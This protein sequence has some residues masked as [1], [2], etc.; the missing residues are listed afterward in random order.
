MS[1]L[2]RRLSFLKFLGESFEIIGVEDEE[3]ACSIGIYDE[4]AVITIFECSVR[5]IGAYIISVDDSVT[6]RV[7]VLA[8][9][10]FVL[11]AKRVVGTVFIGEALFTFVLIGAFFEI[12]T[13]LIRT[14]LGEALIIFA[15]ELITAM[16]VIG[17]FDTMIL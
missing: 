13:I 10:T 15:E 8:S 2:W 5:I 3:S 14:A 6:V 7:I 11:I 9:A 17:A 16:I 12:G 1:A 4:I